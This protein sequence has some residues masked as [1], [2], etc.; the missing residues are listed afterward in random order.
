MTVRFGP[1]ELDSEAAELRK[2]GVRLPL[3]DQPFLV[4]QALLETPGAVVSREELIARLWRQGVHVDFERGLNVAVTRLRQ[5]LLD[6]ADAP[7][8]IETVPRRG[9]RFIGIVESE[10]VPQTETLPEPQTPPAPSPPPNDHWSVRTG[11]LWVVGLLLAM[12]LATGATLIRSR[13]H[14]NVAFEPDVPLPLTSYPG[15]ERRASLSPDGRFVAF[16]WDE[17]PGEHRIYVKATAAGDPV[18][19]SSAN[20]VEFNPAWSP[21]GRQ[22]AFY[23]VET[24]RGL[25]VY[26]APAV[27]GGERKILEF[28]PWWQL[29]LTRTVCTGLLA[30]TPDGKGL[31][32]TASPEISGIGFFFVSIETGKH[33]WLLPPAAGFAWAL[34]PAF[35]PDGRNLAYVRNTALMNGDVYMAPFSAENMSLGEPRRITSLNGMM[36]GLAWLPD[37]RGLVISAGNNEQMKLYRVD[38]HENGEPVPLHIAGDSAIQPAINRMGSLV[39]TRK[40]RDSNIW[41]QEIPPGGSPLPTASRLIASTQLDTSAQS[42]PDGK[43]IAFRSTRSGTYQIWT[44]DAAD[45]GSCVQV[46]REFSGRHVGD[47]N[48][49]PDGRLLVFDAAEAGN[50][51]VWT[52]NSAGGKARRL[53]DHPAEDGWATFSRDGRHIYFQSSRSGMKEIWRIT[54]EGGEP[55]R[56][57]YAGG[58]R[59]MESH[60]KEWLVY[61]R[62]NRGNDRLESLWKRSLRAGS[63][64]VRLVES[65]YL[66]QWTLGSDTLFYKAPSATGP[67]LRRRNLATGLDTFLARVPVPSLPETPLSVSP[68]GRSLLFAQNDSSGADLMFAESFT[69]PH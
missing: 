69:G 19:L 36:G 54:L 63:A 18:R 32:V 65:I 22:I 50:F 23:R 45:G 30:W 21:D 35:S 14:A 17:K 68:D 13:S 47:P 53:T 61:S 16:D 44:C 1:F 25:A 8:F 62:P 27:G 9:Y 51:D 38:L 57:T 11:T 28:T 7:K 66:E 33:H 15:D 60:D 6:S 64:E 41:R 39:Y 34:H 56:I 49:S 20:A 37:G 58:S 59:A 40:T 2:H 3:Q 52:V 42:S 24:P 10:P 12:V 48:W 29:D 55:V 26:V 67:E 43:R 31:V 4:L 5:V 46:T